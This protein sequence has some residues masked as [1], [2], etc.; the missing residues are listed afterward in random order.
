[1]ANVVTYNDRG[2]SIVLDGSTVWD[3]TQSTNGLLRAHPN[4]LPVQSIQLRP[5][6]D[7]TMII[8][9]GGASGRKI[10]QATGSTGNYDF[11]KYFNHETDGVK[12]FKLYIAAA[13]QTADDEIF[14]EY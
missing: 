13:G 1:M 11:I 9:D 2:F 12:M 3:V 8:L 5:K 10:M 6:G 7:T 14:V 4:G